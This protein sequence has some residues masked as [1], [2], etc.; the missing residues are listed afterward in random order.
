VRG[1]QTRSRRR[2]DDEDV[3]LA[4]ARSVQ[5]VE[6]TAERQGG[7]GRVDGHVQVVAVERREDSW[8]PVDVDDDDEIDVASRPGDSPM[9]RRHRSDDDE[10]DADPI[11]RTGNGDEAGGEVDHGSYSGSSGHAAR[12]SSSP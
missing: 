1:G 10:A 4:A 12:T 9:G 8:S 3:D 6:R 7:A 11:E 2:R 5:H